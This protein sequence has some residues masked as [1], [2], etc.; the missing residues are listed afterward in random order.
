MRKLPADPVDL[1]A[2]VSCG[3]LQHVPHRLKVYEFCAPTA[4]VVRARKQATRSRS[5]QECSPTYLTIRNNGGMVQAEK[6]AELFLREGYK[7][8]W[9]IEKSGGV[10]GWRREVS[11]DATQR[12]PVG[13]L[14]RNAFASNLGLVRPIVDSHA[15]IVEKR[16]LNARNVRLGIGRA[17]GR[18]HSQELLQP[19][20]G[21]SCTTVQQ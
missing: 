18:G 21:H 2:H 10:K 7:N 11:W 6:I 3:R 12:A 20:R 8:A 1:D 5:S 16:R 9:R 13:H 14:L 15:E 4:R 19:S 17:C